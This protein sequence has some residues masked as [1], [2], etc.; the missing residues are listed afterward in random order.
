VAIARRSSASLTTIAHQQLHH[1]E[2]CSNMIFFLNNEM[3]VVENKQ[4]NLLLDFKL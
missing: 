3:L 1:K 2:N 4:I